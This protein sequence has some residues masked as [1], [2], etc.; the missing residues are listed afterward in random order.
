MEQKRVIERHSDTWRA[1]GERARKGLGSTERQGL[2]EHDSAR[3]RRKNWQKAG[4]WARQ[5]A[6][7]SADEVNSKAAHPE[8]DSYVDHRKVQGGYREGKSFGKREQE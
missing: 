2:R 8:E 3:T 4:M 6:E 7:K 5:C 1:Q